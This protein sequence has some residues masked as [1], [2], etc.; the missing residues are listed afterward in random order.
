MHDMRV[1]AVCGNY[2]KGGVTERVMEA[3]AEGARG[4]GAQVNILTLRELSFEYCRNCRGCWEPGGTGQPVGDCPIRD[5]LTPWIERVA[6]ADG[7]VLAS[8]INF[9]TLTALFKKFQERCL[10]LTVLKP[11]PRCLRRITGM[12]GLPAPRHRGGKRPLVGITASGA[13]A[14]L[15]G[16]MMP[17]ARKQF[18]A[19]RDTWSGYLV[20]LLWAGGTTA[21]GWTLPDCLLDRARAAG[22][23]MASGR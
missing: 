18:L 17:C 15:G 16:L 13:S 20:D 1:V 11:L 14:V 19:F 23:R 4:A 22:V 8:P 3:V 5:D 9:G 12:D 10:P 6:T 21:K 7:L 2:R